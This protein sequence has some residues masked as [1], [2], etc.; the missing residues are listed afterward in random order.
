VLRGMFFFFPN[1]SVSRD[2]GNGVAICT[3]KMDMANTSLLRS[4][5]SMDIMSTFY[6]TFWADDV[7]D[8]SCQSIFDGVTENIVYTEQQPARREKDLPLKP[9]DEAK[10]W[11]VCESDFEAFGRS[12][13]GE[14]L[15]DDFMRG[16][17]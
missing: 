13:V 3:N 8:S 17:W 12:L 6:Q 11:G 2:C 14:I 16:L 15:K 7:D 4:K 9:E 5:L 1:V 10:W